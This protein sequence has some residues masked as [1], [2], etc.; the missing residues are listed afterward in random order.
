MKRAE[1]ERIETLAHLNTLKPTS[2]VND[3]K[4]TAAD[5]ARFF[6][7]PPPSAGYRRERVV[8]GEAEGF[9]L[10]LILYRQL[11]VDELRPAVIFVHGGGFCSGFPEMLGAHAHAL[12]GCGYVTATI[13]YRVYPET[14]WPGGLEDVKCAVR[15]M[16][17]HALQ[18]GVDPDRIAIA[19]GSA[20][21]YMAAMVALTPGLFEGDGGWSDVSSEVLAAALFYPLTDFRWPALE[22]DINGLIRDFV[23]VDEAEIYSIASPIT[24]V[25]AAAPP[26]LIITGTADREVPVEMVRAYAAR[27]DERGADVELVEF[28][29]RAHAFDFGANDWLACIELM[30]DFFDRVLNNER[31]SRGV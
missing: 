16:R 28:H 29:R 11:V 14:V 24:H 20:G 31:A 10:D 3:A 25:S 17:A 2:L 27:L 9:E 1:R 13:D 12:A 26:T 30:T 21:G 22:P 8:F 19:G 4:V 7:L 5:A 6:T 15:W 23:G 18:L